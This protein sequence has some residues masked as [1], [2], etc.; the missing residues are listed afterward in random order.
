M[1][2]LVVDDEPM[3][4]HTLALVFRRAGFEVIV[5][6]DAERALIDAHTSSPDLVLCDIDL[7]GRD[8]VAL[9]QALGQELPGLPI[10]VLTGFY[11]SLARVRA[12]AR[13]LPQAVDICTKPC[14]PQHLLASAGQL[15]RTA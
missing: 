15:L 14:A 12:C 13:S 10:L 7:P 8:G 6:G 5:A 3:V 1:R 11:G 2:V 9:M 4:A